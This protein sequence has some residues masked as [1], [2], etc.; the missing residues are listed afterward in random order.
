MDTGGGVA[1]RKAFLSHASEDKAS[2]A[3][4]LARELARLGVEPWLDK[5]EIRPGDS[6]VRKLFDEGLSTVDAVIVIVSAVSVNKRWVREELDAAMVSRI[7]NDTR[8][9]PVQLDGAEM[10]APLR[11]LVW[12]T[13]DRSSEDV[14]AAAGEIATTM[15]GRDLRPVV[16]SPPTYATAS[17]V[18]GL[19]AGESL[20]LTRLAE[21]AI[22][23]GHLLPGMNWAAVAELVQ[24]DGLPEG[25]AVEAAHALAHAGF[26]EL[27]GTWQSRILRVQLTHSG[28]G[29][30]LHATEPGYDAISNSVTAELINDPPGDAATL[31]ERIGVP[32]VIAQYFIC[33][34]QNEGLLNYREYLEL[35]SKPHVIEKKKSPRA[36]SNA[37]S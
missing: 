28:L 11:H 26:I 4:P 3:E 16:A 29:T 10:P 37:S 23:Q 21:R 20:M 32:A 25:L 14:K 15:Y 8:L 19:S 22:A 18:P 36:A 35:Y 24:V 34:L 13:S 31:A 17:A 9:I 1:S 27:K 33:E 7:R 5:W 2:F 30:A 6:L 12:I